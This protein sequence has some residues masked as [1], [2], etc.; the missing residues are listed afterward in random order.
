MLMMLLSLVIWFYSN[1]RT[2]GHSFNISSKPIL[3]CAT[4][5]VWISLDLPGAAD[6]V[7]IVLMTRVVGVTEGS[8][9][10]GQVT[11]TF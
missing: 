1:I 7:V 3:R 11:S 2:L 4:D 9:R 6:Q 5:L 10:A 8:S